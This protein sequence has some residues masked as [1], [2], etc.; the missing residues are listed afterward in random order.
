MEVLF[1]PDDRL[2]R[3]RMR[4]KQPARFWFRSERRN[5]QREA[6][7]WPGLRCGAQSRRPGGSDGFLRQRVP[8]P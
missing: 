8:S 3:H 1:H 5:L 6:L 4:A 2:G 7:K